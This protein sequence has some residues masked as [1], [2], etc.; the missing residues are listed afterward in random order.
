MSYWKSDKIILSMVKAE[1]I[2]RENN[3]KLFNIVENLCITDGLPMPKIYVMK[4]SQPNAFATG[5]DKKHATIVFTEGLLQKLDR[6]EIE[7]VAAHELSHIKNRDILL[8]SVIVVLVGVVVLV[9]NLFLRITFWGNSGNR[10]RGGSNN[11]GFIILVLGLLS[12]ILAPIAAALIQLA[13]S[14]KREFLADSSGALLTR[15]P[16]GLANALR[17]ISQDKTPMRVAN[18][19]T[20]HLFIASPF[21][22]RQAKSWLT[23]LFL[24]HPEIEDRI[25][26]LQQMS[27]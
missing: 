22:G 24:T 16:Q 17:K 15:Y 23:K 10:N 6:S 1:R 4:E 7:G 13:V 26:A 19:S 21:K 20:A 8:S 14:R 2:T 12:A 27:V 18:N 5:R 9:S 11:I 3:L 25:K